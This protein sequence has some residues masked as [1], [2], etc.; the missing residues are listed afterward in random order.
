[1]WGETFDRAEELPDLT[2]ELHAHLRAWREEVGARLP[3][4]NPYYDDIL[5][6][7]LPKPDGA[8]NFPAGTASNG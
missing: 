3:T 7:R 2:T 1:M 8:G 6:N 5:A 4:S